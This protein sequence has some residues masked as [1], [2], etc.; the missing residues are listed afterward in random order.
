M[1]HPHSF[2]EPER[3]WSRCSTRRRCRKA[4]VAHGS[5]ATRA[6]K[7]LIPLA[8]AAVLCLGAIQASW[9]QDSARL[10]SP[11][12][13]ASVENAAPMT[14]QRA[15]DLAMSTN[16]DLSAAARELQAAQGPVL[17]GG[18]R[19]NPSLSY[20]M[21][22]TRRATRTTTFQLDQPIELGGKRAAR[23]DAAER[24]RDIAAADLSATRA[25]LR[26]SVV[27]AFYEVLLAQERVELARDS[28]GLAGRASDA[29]G[30]RVQA[31]KISPVEETRARVA[32]S[33]AR[34][35]AAQAQ[36]E[37]T[38]SRQRLSATWGNA[39]PRFVR[40]E[41]TTGAATDLPA[42]PTPQALSA[43]LLVSPTLRRARIEVQRRKALSVL[44]RANRVPDVTVSLG[45]KRDEQLGRDQA[46]I[47]L[48]VPLPLFDRNQGNLLEALRREDQ[49][50]DELAATEIRLETAVLQ[51]RTR[52][53]VFS[54]EAQTIRDT[55]LPGAQSAYDAATKGFELGKFSFLDVLDAQ[56]T[57]FQAKSQYLRA[58]TEAQRA[59]ADIDRLLGGGA[60]VA[61][62]SPTPSQE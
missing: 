38:L 31:G 48:S 2:A 12:R 10:A 15:L 55:V 22:D 27:L 13:A 49:S 4:S 47:G 42:V 19:P 46:V 59:S 50:L 9:A 56:R 26:A 8:S 52:L 41:P 16:A 44:E 51:A 17:Q 60:D 43:R 35:E 24:G 6:S 23:I 53:D 61:A 45:V 14:L 1:Q 32:E 7:I 40:A 39:S 34:L 11:A 57:L 28:V 37:L 36:G 5:A 30:K 29:A 18:A 62:L 21:E 20:L 25:D 54:A 33:A 58:L 3:S